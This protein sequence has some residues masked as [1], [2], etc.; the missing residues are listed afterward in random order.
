MVLSERVR[1]AGSIDIYSVWR[2]VM[3]VSQFH[4]KETCKKR[5]KQE[6]KGSNVL[7]LRGSEVLAEASGNIEVS[8]VKRKVEWK[9][10]SYISLIL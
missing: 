8:T 6:E 9:S 2:P 1:Q 4:N 5:L 3:T 10:L 7:S